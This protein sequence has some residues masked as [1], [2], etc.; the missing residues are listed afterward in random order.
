MAIDTEKV[1]AIQDILNLVINVG[2]EVATIMVKNNI[3]EEDVK[4]LRKMIKEKPEDYFP[5]LK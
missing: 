5:N 2:T 1:K 4:E 3:T